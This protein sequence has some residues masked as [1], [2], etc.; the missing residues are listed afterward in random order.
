ISAFLDTGASGVLLDGDS[1]DALQSGSTSGL[2][3]QS[4]GG[5]PVYFQDVGAVGSDRFGVSQ[6]FNL[7]LAPSHPNIDQKITDG[8]DQYNADGS[9]ANVDLS[10][11]NHTVSSVRA[12]ISANSAPNGDPSSLSGVNV[13]GVP[14][15][16]GTVVVM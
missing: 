4:V 7:S 12:Q 13:F 14:V 6:P 8:Q 3:R 2:P 9:F 1:A 10:Y 11:Y 5:N 15:M 16:K